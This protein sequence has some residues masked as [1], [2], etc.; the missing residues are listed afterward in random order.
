VRAFFI[1]LAL[2]RLKRM[3]LLAVW[4]INCFLRFFRWMRPQGL[5]T[6]PAL[7]EWPV[8]AHVFLCLHQL[9]FT[10]DPFEAKPPTARFNLR[11]EVRNKRAGVYDADDRELVA[12]AIAQRPTT[13][14][15]QRRSLGGVF[16][17]R[18][19]PSA[20]LHALDSHIYEGQVMTLVFTD[21]EQMRSRLPLERAGVTCIDAT[22]VW[23][24]RT[25]GFCVDEPPK[26]EVE[27][28][29]AVA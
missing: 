3:S 12:V 21:E 27:V 26:Q 19:N 18:Q 7:P 24:E 14:V 29:C 25:A 10:L 13:V 6:E 28:A 2:R 5:P 23:V 20:I 9:R 22:C 4:M 11:C 8:G 17:L 1:S 16:D 15:Q